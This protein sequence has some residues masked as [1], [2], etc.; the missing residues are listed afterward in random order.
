MLYA[1][2]EPAEPANPPNLRSRKLRNR[3][4]EGG[5]VEDADDRREEDGSA[6]LEPRKRPRLRGWLH[7]G[8]AVLLAASGL[9][10]EGVTT[11][12]VLRVG[13]LV[14]VVSVTV[15]LAASAAYHVP[16]WPEATAR[17]LRRVDH[18]AIYLGVA[19]TYTPIVLATL[20]SRL[21]ALVLTVV[22]LGTITGIVVRNVFPHARRWVRT[23]P[24]IVLGWIGI[25]ILPGMWRHSVAVALLVLAGGVAYT[26]GAVVY[27]R[28]RPDPWPTTFGYH[29]VFHALTL[30]AIALHWLAV[31]TAV[32]G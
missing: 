15:M 3:L 29:E 7:L 31:R 4:E 17:A 19:G 2:R 28:Q 25:L 12:P 23:G 32:A 14:Y 9:G 22:W 8:G 5:I 21:G 24:N 18:S 13:V 20:A 27:A 1:G 10:L 26:L 6:T 16:R 30:L 11:D